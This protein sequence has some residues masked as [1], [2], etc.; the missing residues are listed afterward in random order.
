MAFVL[1]PVTPL[2]SADEFSLQYD[3]LDEIGKGSFGTVHRVRRRAD[4]RVMVA[5][6]LRYAQMTEREKVRCA[7]A[8]HSRR[9]AAHTASRRPPS[10]CSSPRSTC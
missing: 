6:A 9:S 5:K 3:L 4:D 10:R 7:A 2:M 8:A 1:V